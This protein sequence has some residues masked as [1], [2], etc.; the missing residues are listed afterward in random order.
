V[1]RIAI[2]FMFRSHIYTFSGRYYRQSSGGPIGLR[3]ACAVARLALQMW[4]SKWLARL[5]R[6]LV[7]Y[8]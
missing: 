5:D 7:K 6:L 3:S 4:D 8:E 1:V 2:E